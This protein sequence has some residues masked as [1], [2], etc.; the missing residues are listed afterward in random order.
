[1][2]SQVLQH[3]KTGW[4]NQ[5]TTAMEPFA[6]RK[7]KLAVE[8]NC[9]LWGARVI[10][11]LDLQPK[12]SKLLHETHPGITRMKSL[13]R[14]YV[15]WPGIDKGLECIAKSCQK[16]STTSKGLTKNTITSTGVSKKAMIKTTFRL[17][18]RAHVANCY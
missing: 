17:F 15:W 16:L 6:N 4:P 13:A 14:S 12:M 3:V 7:E 2:L 5:V 11:P 1:M 9:L 10:I 18:S 8:G